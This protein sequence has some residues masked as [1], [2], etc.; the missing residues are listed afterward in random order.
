MGEMGNSLTCMGEIGNSLTCMGEMGNSLT[1]MGE[2]GNSLTCMGE[3]GN[4]FPR[5][6]LPLGISSVP[7]KGPGY[8]L[9]MSLI[10]SPHRQF[11]LLFKLSSGKA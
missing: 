3:M 7:N 1:C 8:S 11:V 4:L 5:E 10:R 9:S 2:I 6:L